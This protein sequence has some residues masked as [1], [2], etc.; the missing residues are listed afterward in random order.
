MPLPRTCGV[1]AGRYQI[2]GGWVLGTGPTSD[3]TR[4]LTVRFNAA[5]GL[6][7]QTTPDA[8]AQSAVP[9]RPDPQRAI[10]KHP[11]GTRLVIAATLIR[12]VILWRDFVAGL[13]GLGWRN[14]TC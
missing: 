6:L 1:G 10:P 4:H 7:H 14:I 8:E 5:G 13:R 12:S 3:A 11:L 2:R 9:S